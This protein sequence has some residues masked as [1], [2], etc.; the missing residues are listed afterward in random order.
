[1][2]SRWPVIILL[3]CYTAC[4]GQACPKL[5]ELNFDRRGD[6]VYMD[7]LLS[8]GRIHR[9]IAS[10]LPRSLPNDTLRLEG[11]RFMALVFKQMR[12]TQRDSSFLYARQLEEQALRYHNTLYA[13][14]AMML[15]EHY[16]RTIKGDFPQALRINQRASELCI[17]LP[18]ESSPR[19]QVQM[20]M[21][22][23]YLL[24]KEYDNAL[25]S[26]QLSQ[27]L[28][29]YNTSL[30]PKNRKL[31]TSQAITQLGEVYEIRGQYELARQQFETSLKIALE[32]RSQVNVA[33]TNERLGDF[34]LSR[35]Q[36][37]EAINYFNDALTVWTQLKDRGGQAAVW[38]RLS[39]GYTLTNKPELAIE[40]GEKA[41]AVA[42]ELGFNRI[43]QMA[44]QSLYQAYR[45]A[46]QP[47]QA[48][49][50][51][52]EYSTLRDSLTNLKRV[53]ELSTVQ[54]KYDINQIRLAAD[55]ERVIQQQQL[56]NIRRQAEIARLR[57]E[58][59][60]DQLA[61]ETRVSQLRQ[62]IETERLR[63]ESQKS[64]LENRAHIDKLRHDIQQANLMRVV[65]VGGLAM[66]LGFVM[67][68]YRKNR[69]INRQKWEI[70]GLNRDLEDKV[71]ARTVELK[72]AN[73]Q[74]R[75]KNREIEEALLRGQTL[76]RKRMAA[77]LH[78]SLGGLLAAIKTSMSA[79]NPAHM[80]EGEQKIYYNLLNMTKEAFAEIRYLSHNLQPDELEKQGLS[81]ALVRLVTKLNLTQ[82]ITFRLDNKELPRLG[83]TAEFNLYSICIELCSNIL[84][85]SEATEADILFR[86]FNNELNM[87]V[88][89]NG[90]GMDP[91]DATGMG[92][93]NIQARMDLIQG[94]Y[95][96]H[97]SKGEGTTFIFILPVAS[98]LAMA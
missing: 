74:L 10:G 88:K 1:M 76:E 8:L 33:Y 87:I 81:E 68:Y 5:P 46:N 37:L 12:G 27:T 94:R 6:A 60:R 93:H 92:L 32:A 52:E 36:P 67:V 64:R 39:E 24:L 49:T 86:R 75:A 21:G 82:K 14:R 70:E 7:S 59:E 30:T 72:L 43:R 19:W 26:Y 71:F 11:L 56:L 40:F 85:H 35:H 22:D 54:K 65:M 34:F 80:A 9:Q 15:Q 41:V 23:I 31:L 2:K 61:G 50:M 83:K 28:L 55:K 77:D 96:I 51:Y 45:L 79:L 89:D 78:D 63:A 48:L 3:G 16:I 13:V 69:L 44:T 53:E 95:E 20:N 66:L 42:R 91:T 25:R 18:R 57:A 47:A 73:D 38:A 97:S 4:F 58:A 62:R 29:G 98:N 17:K 90:C 84:R